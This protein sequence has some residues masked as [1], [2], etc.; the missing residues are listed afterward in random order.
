MRTRQ[1]VGTEKASQLPSISPW[2]LKAFTGYTGYYIR[3]HFQGL[4]LLNPSKAQGLDGWPLLVCLNHP[5][6]WDP[7]IALY[8]SDLFFPSREHRGP[9]ATEGLAKFQFFEKL[10]LFGINP[11]T[12]EGA[13]DFLRIGR[14]VLNR[15]DGA[16]WVTAQGRFTDV[17]VRPVELQA[18]V[19]HLVRSPSKVVVLP[20]ALEYSFWLDR[21]PEAFA[22]VGDPIFIEEGA[23][24]RAQEWRQVFSRSLE[25]TQSDLSKHV[26]SRNTEVFETMFRG[27][28]GVGGVY[29]LWQALKSIAGAR[30]LRSLPRTSL[31]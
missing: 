28:S 8:L 2:L 4:H 24:R 20:L 31:K 19:A 11:H 16:L 17:R 12:R 5:S 22:C 21:K 26:E 18:G 29:D 27:R 14:A 23:R 3:R 13:A 15:P 6:W 9:I 1:V 10:G 25:E 30:P 7:L